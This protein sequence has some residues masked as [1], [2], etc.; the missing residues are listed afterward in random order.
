LGDP[1]SERR[2]LTWDDFKGVPQDERYTAYTHYSIRYSYRVL[3]S[4]AQDL[5]L[6]FE[7]YCELDHQ[8]SWVNKK[9]PG[10]LPYE[11]KLLEHE[12]GHYDICFIELNELLFQFKNNS[13][14]L[15]NYESKIE[16][17]FNDTHI[18]YKKM[19]EDYDRETA[20]S[21]NQVA[22]AKWN[23]NIYEMLF[24]AVEEEEEEMPILPGEESSESE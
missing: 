9:S 20:H 19:Q 6:E 16:T 2:L 4:P 13:Y 18:K 21:L 22:Q 23:L 1:D 11:K 7:G 17:I 10:F 14:T 12:Q 15:S 3:P 5:E 8:K 24:P